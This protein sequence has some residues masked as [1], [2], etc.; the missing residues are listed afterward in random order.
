[1]SGISINGLPFLTSV[2]QFFLTGFLIVTFLGLYNIENR[3]DMI[4]AGLCPEQMQDS[5][6]S[7]S[8]TAPEGGKRSGD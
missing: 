4:R 3:T 5:I 1:M 2:G 8:I 7:K 6:V